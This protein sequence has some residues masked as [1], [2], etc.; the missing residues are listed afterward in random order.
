MI[1]VGFRGSSNLMNWLYDFNFIQVS[2]YR[3]IGSNIKVEK[4]FFELYSKSKKDIISNIDKISQK[5]GNNKIIITGHSLGGAESTLLTF[6]LAFTKKFHISH[7]TFGSP[8]V[9]NK[10]FVEKY[11]SMENNFI[12]WRIVHYNDIVPHVPFQKIMDFEHISHE[13]WYN[14]PQSK[15]IICNETNSLEPSKKC[16]N[17]LIWLNAFAHL[18][19]LNISMGEI[20][21]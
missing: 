9:G 13:I 1:I 19:Y 5:Y 10:D 16:S 6:D 21:C 20:G 7:V 18:N 3:N 17:S 14:N 4:G 2:P 8:R 15:Y 11:N 12:E